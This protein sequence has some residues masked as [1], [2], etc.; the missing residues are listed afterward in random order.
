[1]TDILMKKRTPLITKLLA[2]CLITA[3]EL[4]VVVPSVCSASTYTVTSCDDSSSAL[5]KPGTLRYGVN[6]ARSGDEIDLSS[7]PCTP[8]I[9]TLTQGA[10]FINQVSLTFKA[11]RGQSVAISGDAAALS[12]GLLRH[13]GTG[14]LEIDYLTTE[15]G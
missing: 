10:L 11:A 3:L 4:E 13:Q 7:L 15:N 2:L 9:I 12:D 5:S 1:M 8:S 6:N 14:T